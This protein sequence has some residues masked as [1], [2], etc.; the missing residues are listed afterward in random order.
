M[1]SRLD[2]MTR[3]EK[4][5]LALVA[6]TIFVLLN[7]FLISSLFKQQTLLRA[8]I[9]T[10][11]AQWEAMQMLYADREK[12]LKRD[13]WLEEKQ[14]KFGNES[15]AGVQLL[16]QIKAKAKAAEVPIENPS[17]GSPEK[18]PYYEGV[19]VTIE[20]KSTWPALVKFLASLQQPEQFIVL[21]SA[22]LQIE[23]SDPSLMRGKF[24]VARWQAPRSKPR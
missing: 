21:E 5:L 16:D 23:S 15:E 22:N 11:R 3:R 6:G 18:S 12:W 19:P 10:K 8:Q 4:T 1:S 13:K 14:P 20:T 24:R 2:R 17:I 9:A 7:L